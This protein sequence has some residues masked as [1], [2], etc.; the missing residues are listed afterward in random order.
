MD[1]IF[2]YYG[3]LLLPDI[4]LGKGEKNLQ[5]LSGP[6]HPLVCTSPIFR[7]KLPIY[8]QTDSLIYFAQFQQVTESISLPVQGRLVPG[9][10]RLR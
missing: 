6:E 7:L 3:I 8:C 5:R 4:D 10:L 1:V 9:P 2:R